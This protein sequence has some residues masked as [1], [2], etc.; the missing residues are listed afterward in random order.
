MFTIDDI[1]SPN[2]ITKSLIDCDDSEIIKEFSLVNSGP[3]LDPSDS[4]E[5]KQM[6]IIEW[7][8][9]YKKD[10]HVSIEVPYTDDEKQEIIDF[11][12]ANYLA[13]QEML[14]SKVSNPPIEE[15]VAL[16]AAEIDKLKTK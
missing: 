9:K 13:K 12:N 15:Q 4:P 3:E 1:K 7:M 5:A 2:K 16:L 6:K 8:K 10:R 14:L 11:W